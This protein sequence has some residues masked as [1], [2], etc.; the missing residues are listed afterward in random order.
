MSATTR[1]N[2]WKK[3]TGRSCLALAR[4]AGSEGDG[5]ELEPVATHG[6]ADLESLSRADALVALPEDTTAA[7]PGDEVDWYELEL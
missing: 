1:P 3:K 2:F 7:G 5:V 6:S 4:Q